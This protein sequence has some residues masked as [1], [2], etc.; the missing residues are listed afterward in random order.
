[1]TSIKLHKG[2]IENNEEEGDADTWKAICARAV[3]P[4]KVERTL[5]EIK[6]RLVAND[7]TFPLR[8]SSSLAC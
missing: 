1:M 8:C 5:G 6:D 4:E 2:S 3:N 7:I